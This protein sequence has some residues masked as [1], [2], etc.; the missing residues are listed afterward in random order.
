MEFLKGTT[1]PGKSGPKRN[2]NEEVLHIT[3][4]HQNWSSVTIWQFSVISRT[5]PLGFFFFLLLCREYS[6]CNLSTTDRAIESN[7]KVNNNVGTV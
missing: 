1:T 4:E 2:G 3:P 6:Q 5:P 7:K